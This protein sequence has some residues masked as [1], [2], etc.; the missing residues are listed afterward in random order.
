M[1]NR[2]YNPIFIIGRVHLV[3]LGVL[4][5]L[6]FEVSIAKRFLPSVAVDAYNFRGMSRS[7]LI[8]GGLIIGDICLKIPGVV[9]WYSTNLELGRIHL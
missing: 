1:G 6:F 7:L 5:F 2:G 8:D 9:Q 4:V 3:R